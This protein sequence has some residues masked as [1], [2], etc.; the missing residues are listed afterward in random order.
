VYYDARTKA[1]LSSGHVDQARTAA[2][3]AIRLSKQGLNAS[4]TD[5]SQQLLLALT[6]DSMRVV[7][8]QQGDLGE[9]LD[10]SVR[11]VA[12]LSSLHEAEPKNVDYN[13]GY[14]RSLSNRAEV[15]SD[16][17]D[18]AAA[19]EEY[20]RAIAL[21][22]EKS[23]HYMAFRRAVIAAWR[24]KR[25]LS[26]S[27]LVLAGYTEAANEAERTFRRGELRSPGLYYLAQVYALCAR[28]CVGDPKL[29][30]AVRSEK[31]EHYA[32]QAVA[33]LRRDVDTGLFSV[34]L[35]RKRFE[36]DRTFDVLRSRPD[37][38]A[39]VADIDFP[40]DPFTR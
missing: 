14:A 25:D 6:Y 8:W 4:P 13:E 38:Q 21:R 1:A 37:F 12:I 18:F 15:L 35:H 32:A 34:P 17:G 5:L 23:G 10:W 3:A 27:E 33:M 7:E 28:A 19:V 26:D 30:Q 16:L 29:A 2:K 22:P 9:A 24:D 31:A 40:A 39:V 20:D 36:S 11:V